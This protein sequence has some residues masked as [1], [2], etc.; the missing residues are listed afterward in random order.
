MGGGQESADVDDNEGEDDRAT[1]K[2]AEVTG[3]HWFC[4]GGRGGWRVIFVV[5][6]A[7]LFCHV[8]VSQHS[9]VFRVSIDFDNVGLCR[10]YRKYFLYTIFSFFAYNKNLR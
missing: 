2:S 4:V 8:V 9:G 1:E 10:V 3:D 7:G 5:A 6:A